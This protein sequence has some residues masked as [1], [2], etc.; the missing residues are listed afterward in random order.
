MEVDDGVD[1]LLR[2]RLGEVDLVA[3][4]ES[5]TVIQRLRYDVLRVVLGAEDRQIGCI[6]GRAQSGQKIDSDLL[7]VGMNMLNHIQKMRKC[8]RV[9]E[10]STVLIAVA[11]PT[12]IEADIT[13]AMSFDA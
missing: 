8:S 3:I 7:T 4:A 2:P 13:K 10:R 5:L 1:I 11:A 12:R 9:P 6:N